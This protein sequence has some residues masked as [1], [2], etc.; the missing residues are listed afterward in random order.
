MQ[1]KLLGTGNAAGMPL[2][3]CNCNYCVEVSADRSLQ[4]TPC[5]ALLKVDN[6]RYLLDAGQMN[7]AERFPAGSLDG[8]FITHFHPDHVQGLF[9]LRWGINQSLPVYT[10]PDTQG[11]ADLYKHS[12]ILD[13]QP[14]KKFTSL[15]L[16]QLTVT[17]L[18]LIHSK[19]TFG[20]LFEFNGHNM[21][22]L[23]DT[24]GMPDTSL[25]LLKEC[26]PGVMVIDCSFVPY[27]DNQ[28]HNNL[29][30]VFVLQK[31]VQA[32]KIVLTHIGH[33]MDIWLKE[34][35]DVLPDDYRAGYDE[36]VLV[37]G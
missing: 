5:S 12:G 1:L 11:C 15:R 20:Y 19:P 18:P 27:S 36:M 7:L 24:K 30:D 32:G 4:R 34:N 21:A 16:G 25:E 35:P 23:T 37:A 2:Y 22:Y 6:K 8:I 3:G 9:H 29:E 10:P 33:D 26:Q 28:T 17:P 31:Q 13:F 14:L